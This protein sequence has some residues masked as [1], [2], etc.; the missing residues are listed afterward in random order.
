MRDALE[1][2]TAAALWVER[3]SYAAHTRPAYGAGLPLPL[4]LLLPWARRRAGLQRLGPLTPAQA[5]AG[6]GPLLA[7]CLPSMHGR[8]G[9]GC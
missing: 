1:P 7:A 2:A 5:R 9:A 8:P 6:A 3:H 4:S